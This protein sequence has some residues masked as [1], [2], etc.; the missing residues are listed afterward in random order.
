MG[1]GG[2]WDVAS[3]ALSV[4]APLHA[5]VS[6]SRSSLFPRCG[7][8]ACGVQL[9]SAC[10]SL[11]VTIDPEEERLLEAYNNEVEADEMEVTLANIGGL[12][13]DCLATYVPSTYA[14]FDQ[15]HL[16]CAARV[17]SFFGGGGSLCVPRASRPPPSRP[18]AFVSA[19]SP[20]APRAG[21][22]SSPC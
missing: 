18:T 17:G 19:T 11:A 15:S 1:R 9:L 14:M 5:I 8:G 21:T 10:M 6:H 22:I 13:V 16:C 12:T 4:R 3:A 20:C 7:C 2:G